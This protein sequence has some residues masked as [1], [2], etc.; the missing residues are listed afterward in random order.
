MRTKK[1]MK[2]YARGLAEAHF[3]SDEDTLWEPF[4]KWSEDDIED[5]IDALAGA[6]YRAMLWVQEGALT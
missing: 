1:E 3:Y 2:I 5:E 4:E 6:V